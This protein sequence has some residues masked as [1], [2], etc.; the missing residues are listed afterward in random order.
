V[1]E[2]VIDG[3]APVLTDV[4]GVTAVEPVPG[5]VGGLRISVTGSPEDLLA[6][7][8]GVRVVRLRTEE[9]SL[10]EIFLTYY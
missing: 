10:E 2:V 5:L 6:R 9:P 1:V 7:L 4:R 3:P 8:A